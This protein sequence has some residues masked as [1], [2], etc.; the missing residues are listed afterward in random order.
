MAA[1][2]YVEGGI[3]GP[4]VVL[5]FVTSAGWAGDPAQARELSDRA[6][7]LYNQARF[8]E[9]EALYRRAIEAWAEAGADSA[10]DLATDK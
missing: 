10:H 4:I 6:A 1:Q 5:L 7:Q 8:G 2:K 3:T 9:A